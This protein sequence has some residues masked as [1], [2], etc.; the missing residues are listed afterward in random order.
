MSSRKHAGEV[1]PRRRWIGPIAGGVSLALLVTLAVVANGFD[2]RETPREDPSVWVERVAGQY[3]RVNTETAEIDTVRIAESTSGVVQS[4]DF[5]LLLT[6]GLGRAWTIDPAS[7]QDVHDDVQGAE[8]EALAEDGAAD[9]GGG[10]E[11]DTAGAGDSDTQNE[12]ASGEEQD[13][14]GLALRT[15]EGTRQVVAAGSFVLFFTENGSAY[16]SRIASGGARAV[17]GAPQLLDPLAVTRDDSRDEDEGEDAERYRAD[18]AAIDENGLVALFSK[19]EQA[20]RW[21]D[22]A[23]GEWLGGANSVSADVSDDAQLAVIGEEWALFDPTG[24][25][26]WRQGRDEGTSLDLRGVGMLQAS[27]ALKT[28]AVLVADEGGLWSVDASGIASR[29]TEAGGIAAQPRYV[30]GQPIAAWVGAASAALWSGEGGPVQLQFDESVKE[31]SEAEPEIRSNGTRAVLVERRTGMMW[32]APGGQLIPVEQ[33]SLVDPPKQDSGTVVTQD[34]TEQEPPVAVADDFGV[35]AGEPVLLP[36]LLND[37]DPNRKDVL[38]IVGEGLGEG[39]DA[40]FGSLSLLSD[41]QGVI[42]QAS[43]AARGNVSFSYR[44]TDGVN[45]SAPALVT[46]RVVDDSVNSAPEWCQVVGCQRSWPSPE[47]APGGTLILPMLESWVDP[48]GDPMMLASAVVMNEEDPLRA[49]VTADGKLAV[50][51]TDPNAQAGDVLV[52]VSVVDS[53]GA[54]TERDLRVRVRTGA[55]IEFAAAAATVKTGE[56]TVLRPLERATGGSGSFQLLDAV[57][58][59]GAAGV[60]VNQGL[61]TIDVLAPSAGS[62]LIGVTVRDTVTEQETNGIIRV[63]AVE[64]RGS[65]AVPPLRA[66]VRAL[67]DSTVEVLSAIPGAN[68]RALTV[69]S[70]HVNDGQLRADVIEHA[71]L[72]VSGSTADGQPGRI[73]SVDV[74]VAEG[75]I[76]AQGRLTVFQVA[77]NTGGAIAVADTA[78]VRAGSVVDIDVLDNDVSPP[79]ER[80]VL[81]PQVSAP[82]IDG[83]LAFASGSKVRYLAPNQPGTYSLSYTTYSASNPE[84]SDI[85]QVRVTVL[86]SGSNRDPQP[87]TITVR[88]APGEK[89]TTNVPLSAVDPDGDRVRLV[90]VSAPD[91][92]QLSATILS[93]TNALQIEAS[94]SASRGTQ[95]TSYTVRDAFGGEADGL[96]RIIVT[97]PDQGG[98]APVVYSDYVRIVRG[99]GD[100]AVVRP[101]DNDIDPSGGTLELVSVVPNVPGDSQTNLYRQLMQRIDLSQQKQGIVRIIGGEDL[102]TVS[103][104]YT[105]QSSVSKSTTDGLIVVQVSER[106]GVQAPSVVDTVLSVRDRA[107]FERV[108]VDVVT[109]RVRWAGGDVSTLELSLWGGSENRYR[110]NGSNILGSYRA[111]GDLVVFRLAGIDTNGAEVETFGFLTIPPLDELRLSL[112]PGQNAVSVNENKDIEVDIAGLLDLGASDRV[113]IDEGS[114]SVQRPQ[115]SCEATGPTSFK[116]SAGKEAPW[117]DSCTVRV[118]LTEQRTYTYLPIPISIVPDAPVVLLNP[119]T[120]T[121]APGEGEVIALTDMVTWQG[122]RA[123]SLDE[124][125]WQVAGNAT[126]FV[127]KQNGASLDVQTRA[128]S[129]PGAQ[130]LL[131]VTVT[132]SGDSQAVLTLRVGEAAIDAPKGGTVAL[133]CTVGSSCSA[134]LTG[135]AGEYDPFA[136]KTGGGLRLVAVDD[137]GCQFGSMQATGESV[138]VSWADQRGPGGKCTASFTVKDAQNRTGTG[139]IEFDAQGVPRAPAS[140]SLSNYTANSV[141]LLVD[142]GAASNAHPELTGVIV[143]GVSVD[144]SET[145]TGDC[146]PVGGS[147]VCQVS[148]LAIGKKYSFSAKAVNSVG[149]SDATS[150]VVAWAFD[151]PAT[152]TVTRVEQLSAPSSAAGQVQFSITVGDDTTDRYVVAMGGDQVEVDAT[153]GTATLNAVQVGDSVSWSVTPVSKYQPPMAGSS[154]SGTAATGSMR[155]GGQPQLGAAEVTNPIGSDSFDIKVV[156]DSRHALSLKYAA[157]TTGVCPATEASFSSDDTFGFSGTIGDT[158]T[159]SVC[160][161]NEWGVAGPVSYPVKIGGELPALQVSTGYSVSGV[162]TS[163]GNTWTYATLGAAPT[164]SNQAPGTNIVYSTGATLTLSVGVVPQVWQCLDSNPSFCSDPVDL[165]RVGPA[166]ASVTWDSA[167]ACPAAPGPA[168][169][170]F[171]VLGSDPGTYTATYD[172]TVNKLLFS[173]VDGRGWDSITV[174]CTP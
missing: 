27:T 119:L 5:G 83:E 122:G 93:R 109:D 70:A 74:V 44:I 23:T 24:G 54:A 65:F 9:E 101:L 131:T 108:G 166:P 132:G 113:E 90:A 127:V 134:Q 11:S 142:L 8:N 92:A 3:A 18:A 165:S 137:G 118:R 112:K 159:V 43:P 33:W 63:T 121:I 34:V 52:R 128:D 111:E 155:V 157:S 6:Q 20:V 139:T 107:D 86:P 110:V 102:G 95:L 173:W 120:R 148:S 172:G 136:G 141:S 152:P 53:R 123:G 75:D 124:L 91:D 1:T 62:S 106:V 129:V 150:P 170:A 160:V 169:T 130:E 14:S 149:E 40:G 38:T 45:I 81:H 46:L 77:E 163:S 162:S 48:E 87:A 158:L 156:G 2:S 39:L 57:V 22:A 85:G 147:Y 104:K 16:I 98:G 49:L 78:T 69:Q 146:S 144:S 31:L 30:A 97:D 140:I 151:R 94:T 96:L 60:T 79:G 153:L 41:G 42:V 73:G 126:S 89:V 47:I 105:V 37:Y 56:A 135:V 50:R 125:Q 15:P 28:D 168:E 19:A 64:S 21:F 66:F 10:G 76:T 13:S 88:V 55:A 171:T 164:F 133:Q 138:T 154:S 68:S 84:L 36:L 143:S 32:T 67:A 26:L 82:G 103:F 80:L 115:A 161:W 35:R 61:G 99:A 167:D 72:R 58:Q 25:T 7:P 71:R 12:Q 51:H 117:S 174:S 100:P 114:F 116:Y 59:Q 4:N 17:L 29:M 145:K